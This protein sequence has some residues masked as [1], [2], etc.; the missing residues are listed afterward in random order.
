VLL[1]LLWA[2]VRDVSGWQPSG[3]DAPKC[4]HMIIQTLFINETASSAGACVPGKEKTH[5]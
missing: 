3:E 1:K 4:S 2:G 5:Q